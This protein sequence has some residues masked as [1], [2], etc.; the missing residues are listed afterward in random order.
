MTTKNSISYTQTNSVYAEDVKE[1]RALSSSVS[2]KSIPADN[3]YIR[4]DAFPKFKDDERE[5]IAFLA[6]EM[7][8]PLASINLS[9]EI[10]MDVLQDDQHKE[11][12]DIILRNSLRI[13][14]LITRLLTYQK[15]E[16]EEASHSVNGLLDE[17]LNIVDDRLKLKSITVIKTFS[18]DDFVIVANEEKMKIAFTNIIVNAI[19][20]MP[21]ETGILKLS[22]KYIAGKYVIEIEDNG[23]GIREEDLQSIFNAGFTNKPGGLG[24]G[25]PITKTI[26][27]ANNVEIKVESNEGE[28]TRFILLFNKFVVADEG[29]KDLGE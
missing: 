10:L 24:F 9:A 26:L 20:A 18:I 8:N 12:L 15:P 3:Y 17:V 4:L 25:L 14:D 6:H 29:S 19:D 21:S 11:Y 7:R 2:E 5:F 16:K 23:C 13:N 1:M 27:Q 28:F 22:G